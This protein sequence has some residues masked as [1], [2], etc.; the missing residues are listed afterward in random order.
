[1]GL[2]SYLLLLRGINV[3]GKNK[4]PMKQLREYL[5]QVGYQEVVTYIA[6]GNVLVKSEL[7]A[8]AVR[9]EVEQL[10]PKVFQLDSELVKVLV[11]TYD[12]LNEI[13]D[14]KPQGFGQQPTTYHSDV[15]FLI[16]TDMDSATKAIDKREGVD[17]A[18]TGPGVF[19]FQRLSAERTKSRL[20]K[21]IGTPVYRSL[22]IR[23][24][25]TVDKL[26]EM[27]SEY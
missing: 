23:S 25:T 10:L 9:R 6:S 1:M 12:Q 16:D 17:E 7:S 4:V 5:E 21:I 3:G 2:N 18:W 19:Y 8:E 15:I 24:W 26:R 11:L 27:M 14:R 13:Y 22:T 20:G